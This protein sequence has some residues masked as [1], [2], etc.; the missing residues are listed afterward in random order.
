MRTSDGKVFNNHSFSFVLLVYSCQYSHGLLD[1][2]D[3]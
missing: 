2:M 1:N 3:S